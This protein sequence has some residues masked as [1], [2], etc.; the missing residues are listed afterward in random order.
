MPDLLGS[1]APQ[2]GAVARAVHRTASAISRW[3]TRRSSACSSRRR[4]GCTPPIS[5]TTAMPSV[6]RDQQRGAGEPGV[7]VGRRR[8]RSPLARVQPPAE[9]ADVGR[10]AR[11][12]ARHL[13]D[14]AGPSTGW[15]SG[16]EQRAR[17]AAE[18]V[19][20]REQARRGRRHR[21]APR[22]CRR[23]PRP[24]RG[25]GSSRWSPSSSVAAISRRSR[26][27]G[28]NRVR[29]MPSGARDGL[30]EEPRRA[31]SPAQ[32]RSPSRAACS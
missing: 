12:P 6:G 2:I 30:G 26:C 17:E 27:G 28:R 32:R 15:R 22:R 24:R 4:T 3:T 1:Q 25:P 29:S 10:R 5:R 11:L 23:A 14:R 20:G 31:A 7:P 19:G 21:R 18:V 16:I 8:P 13:G 9:R